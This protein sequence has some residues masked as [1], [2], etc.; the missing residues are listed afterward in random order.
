M[1]PS[2]ARRLFLTLI[3]AMIVASVALSAIWGVNGL[4]VRTH[5]QSDLR[6]A[7]SRLATID[8]E[9]QRLL[10]EL[11]LMDEDPVVLE[12]MVAEE[13]GWG[14]NDATIYRFEDE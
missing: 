1:R 13:L 12:R 2:L 9:N 10:R 11:E 8:R 3:P 7:T 5:L 4:V 6:D 14:R